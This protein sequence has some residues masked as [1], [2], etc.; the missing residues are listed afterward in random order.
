MDFWNVFHMKE[1]KEPTS[2]LYT[3]KATLL[4]QFR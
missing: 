4:S 3:S 1:E 2:G